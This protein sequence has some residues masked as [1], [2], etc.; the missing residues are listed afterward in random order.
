MSLPT[1]E[2][3]WVYQYTH[4]TLGVI[5]SVNQDLNTSGAQTTDHQTVLLRI[6][7]TLLGF[8]GGFW[9]VRRSSNGSSVANSD[10]WTTAASIVW[11]NSSSARSWLVLVNSETGMEF[12][13]DCQNSG[14]ADV[15]IYNRGLFGFSFTGFTATAGTTTARPTAIDEQTQNFSSDTSNYWSLSGHW[16]PAFDSAL[17]VIQSSD[18]KNT[19]VF[20]FIAGTP[21]LSMCMDTVKNPSTG[22]AT[23]VVYWVQGPT[24]ACWTYAD[25]MATAGKS[26]LMKHSSTIGNAYLTTEGGNAGPVPAAVT[27]LNEISGVWNYY[28]A[29]VASVVAGIRGQH[30]RIPDFYFVP[31]AA[32]N[33]DTFP[34]DGSR[35]WVVV[36]NTIQ[37]WNGT[38]LLMA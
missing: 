35:L 11:H 34:A 3:T 33:G 19:R 22:W 14:G 7:Q 37:P 4:P 27:S 21:R 17:H 16:P 20:L 8:A 6:K 1:K 13:I 2:K 10:L 15:T 31:S 36:G 24:D 12:L 18:G 29:G 32:I 23:P 38:S 26:P 25:L 28:K 30:G 5:S 9:T